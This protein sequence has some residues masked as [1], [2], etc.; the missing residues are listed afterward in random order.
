MSVY[1]DSPRQRLEEVV[2]HLR[3][4]GPALRVGTGERAAIVHRALESV[5]RDPTLAARSAP[6]AGLSEPMAAWALRTTLEPATRARLEQLAQAPL[7]AQHGERPVSLA[8][9]VLA[10]N[11]FT[12]ALRAVA[13]PLLFGVPTL[14]K[15]ASRGDEVLRAF[16]E[17]LEPPLRDALAVVTFPRDDARAAAL[18]G[19]AEVVHVH[20]N[21]ESVRRMRDLASPGA[22]VLPHGHGV[23]VALV[24]PDGLT[25]DERQA[26]MD[27]LAADVAAYDGRGCLSPL[28]VHVVGSATRAI[29]CADRLHHAL[30]RLERDLPRG[31]LPEAI[32]GRQMQWRGLAAA[33]GTLFEGPAHAVA[34]EEDAPLPFAPGYRNVSVHA[35]GDEA[36]FLAAVRPLGAHLKCVGVAGEKLGAIASALDHA[37]ALVPRVCPLGTMQ[38]PPF[39]L[40]PEAL[41]PWTGLYRRLETR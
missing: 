28:R 23:G 3:S 9:V 35:V 12:A 25:Y 27:S 4:Q 31:P 18:L 10:G 33:T 36:A 37:P 39:D 11:V 26:A 15:A 34:V 2:E 30:G 38:T 13:T 14:V 22:L 19:S 21:D 6:T 40:W 16:A 17:A 24:F 7:A 32:A 1:R 5:G 20:G 41:P 8:A 29:E